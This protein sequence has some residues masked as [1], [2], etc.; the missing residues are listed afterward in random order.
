VCKHQN[1]THVGSVI[2]LDGPLFD[3]GIEEANF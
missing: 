1:S 3:K 2:T